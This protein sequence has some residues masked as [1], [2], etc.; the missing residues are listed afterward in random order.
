MTDTAL[1]AWLGGLAGCTSRPG[2]S[3][4][5]VVARDWTEDRE[6]SEE[7]GEVEE[8]SRER[9]EEREAAGAGTEMEEEDVV[10]EMRREERVG[11]CMRR[12]SLGAGRS[13]P[14]WEIR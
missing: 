6:E 8:E 5:R 2:S 13:Q 10:E 12:R 7:E 3:S 4:P 11:L 1:A 14:S 9:R